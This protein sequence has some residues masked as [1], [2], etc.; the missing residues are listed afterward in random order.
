MRVGVPREIKIH[1]YRVGL[2][3]GTVREYVRAGH[4][5]ESGAGA[6]DEIYRMAGAAVVDTDAEVLRPPI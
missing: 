5:V 1:E 2:T 4:N 3:P 6:G